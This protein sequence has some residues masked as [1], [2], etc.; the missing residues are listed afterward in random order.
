MDRLNAIADAHGLVVLEDACHS[1]GGRWKGRGTGVLGRCGVFS[2]QETKNITS[3]EGGAIVT[4]DEE[5]AD[6]CRSITN[7]G[8]AKGSEWY[9]H[10]YLGT[11]ARLTEF[12]AALL[13]AQL[14]RLDDQTQKRQRNAAILR[15]GL[16]EMEGIT[17]QPD[18]ERI[19]RRAWHLFCLRIDPDAFGCSRNRFVEA[20]EAE[21]LPIGAGYGRPIYAQPVF[22]EWEGGVPYG[23][24]SCPVTEDLCYRSGMWFDHE[25]LLGSEADMADIL[26][27]FEKVHA[28]ASGL[29]E[30]APDL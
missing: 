6:L 16:S 2:F 28:N 17:L 15:K 8:R 24:V 20:A 10:A 26:G 14:T 23:S 4:D 11:N 30:C 18:D 25:I 12:Q 1:W 21:G 9:G 27:I 22:A 13:S 5:L 29:A 3:A 19:T 7:C